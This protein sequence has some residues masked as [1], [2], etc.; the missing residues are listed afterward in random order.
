ADVNTDGWPDVFIARHWHPA[1]L[2]LNNQNGTFSAA[3]T[4]FCAPNSARAAVTSRR[5]VASERR[6]CLVLVMCLPPPLS[7]VLSVCNSSTDSL[8]VIAATTRRSHVHH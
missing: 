5:R 4:A 6:S 2:W 8:Y 1:N 7:Y 3:D